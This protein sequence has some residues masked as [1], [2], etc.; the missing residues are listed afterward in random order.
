MNEVTPINFVARVVEAGNQQRD[1]LQPESVGVQ[2]ANRVEDRFEAPAE[3]AVVTVVE[4]L[5]IDFVQID[6]R[7]QVSPS[8]LRRP[9]AVR[10]D[11]R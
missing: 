9:V 5:E 4:A 8:T 10:H 1:D 6:P 7:P 11:S 2:A 3:L